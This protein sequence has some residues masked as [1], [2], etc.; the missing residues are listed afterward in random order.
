[1]ERSEL[2]GLKWYPCPSHRLDQSA[3]HRA[4]DLEIPPNVA[5]YFQPPYGPELN[6]I[7]QL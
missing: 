4:A 5:F 6:P 3:V 1:M 7:E 2:G